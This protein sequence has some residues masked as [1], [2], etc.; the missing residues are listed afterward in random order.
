MMFTEFL[1]KEFSPFLQILF[2]N[3]FPQFAF[4]NSSPLR[5]HLLLSSH[6]HA[7]HTPR[8][9]Q[10]RIKRHDPTFFVRT[11]QA[12]AAPSHPVPPSH[13]P[14][15]LFPLHWGLLVSSISSFQQWGSRGPA[16]HS[17][18]KSIKSRMDLGRSQHFCTFTTSKMK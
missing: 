10:C 14:P 16:S 2:S 6:T 12:G 5:S 3:H 18:H 4:R 9:T 1:E 7:V 13:S 11:A 17:A 15:P 8:Q